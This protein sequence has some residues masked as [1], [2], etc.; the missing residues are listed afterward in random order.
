MSLKFTGKI[1]LV[2]NLSIE[3]NEEFSDFKRISSDLTLA[4][5]LE[6]LKKE[7]AGAAESSQATSG[8]RR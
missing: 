5:A 4:Q 3:S 1:L 8:A 2:K 7:D 6:M